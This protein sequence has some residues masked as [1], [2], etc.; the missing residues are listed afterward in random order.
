[1]G[2]TG[3]EMTT[4][5][6][7]PDGTQEQGF[8]LHT[9]QLHCYC[10]VRLYSYTGSGSGSDTMRW[11]FIRLLHINWTGRG[12][13]KSTPDHDLDALLNVSPGLSHFQKAKN[14]FF[15]IYHFLPS[16]WLKWVI[17]SHFYSWS[18]FQLRLRL[19]FS[20]KKTAV[21]TFFSWFFFT[22]H[23]KNDPKAYV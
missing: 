18:F 21:D 20:V 11:H 10:Y 7:K 12:K 17:L 6:I 15:Q 14:I 3:S 16:D 22:G 1:M 8:Q 9:P 5:L 19:G 4:A 13:R 23:L 2:G